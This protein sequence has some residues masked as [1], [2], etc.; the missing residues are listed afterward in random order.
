MYPREFY[1]IPE[2]LYRIGNSSGPRLSHIRSSE[3]D[4]YDR[5]G[6]LM[7]RANNKGISLYDANGL[8]EAG[9][10]GWAWKFAADTFVPMGLK[11]FNDAQ[12]HFMM[13]PTLEMPLAKYKGLLEE[14]ALRA[15]KA[16][17]VDLAL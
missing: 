3:I 6:V 7:I 16:F 4:T 12:G 5:N 11:V 1:I 15:Q 2:E 17:K 8:K 13:V 14:L 9:L 10:T